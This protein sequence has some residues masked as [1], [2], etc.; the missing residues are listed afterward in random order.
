MNAAIR[1]PI[2]NSHC[3]IHGVTH[4]STEV[5]PRC[6][7]DAF[8]HKVPVARC[9]AD[10]VTPNTFGPP[11]ATPFVV[12][13]NPKQPHGDKKVP[14]GYV[15]SGA[16]LYMAKAFKEGARKYGPLNWR[17]TKVEA[18]TYAHAALRH[19]YQWLDGEDIDPESGQPNIAHAMAC[20]AI[21]ADAEATNNLID[22]RPAAGRAGELIRK[23]AT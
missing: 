14:L 1:F 16:M 7:R 19:F 8:R 21:L 6:F 12:S 3:M 20:L 22:N 13:A 23:E 2:I 18:M 11:T 5:C 9:P 10:D 17:I 4:P 15:P